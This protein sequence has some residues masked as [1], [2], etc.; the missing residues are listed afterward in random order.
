MTIL[1][2]LPRPGLSLKTLRVHQQGAV[3]SIEL[4][5]PEQ[6]NAVTDMMLDDLRAVLDHQD[7]QVRVVVLSGAGDDFCLGGDRSEFVPTDP[8]AEGVRISG[9]KARRVYEALTGN[10]AVTIA[11]VQGRAVGAGLGLALACDLRVGSPDA[12]FRL[13]ELALGLPTAWAGIL[14][15]LINEVGTARAR[16]LVLTGR[17]VDA[18]E[19]L[20]LS[21]LH[22]VVPAEAIDAA[23]A[24][25]AKPIIRRPPAALRV[26]K[27]L[28]NSYS[29]AT[30]LADAS[31]LE[32]E[33]MAAA[34]AETHRAADA[35]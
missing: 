25:W 8:A 34:V 18:Q 13:P 19:A 1:P 17:A 35:P 2:P 9:I 28:F 3:L 10:P 21:L 5:T 30:L 23:V 7:P 31:V 32:A 14:P 15:R 12:S 16:D 24:A 4:S 22:K 33:L 6:G 29:A 27:T 11:R 20:S 26:T